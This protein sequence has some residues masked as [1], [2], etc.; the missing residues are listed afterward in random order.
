MKRP[1]LVLLA[2]VV[3]LL[4]GCTDTPSVNKGDPLRGETV[5]KVCLDCHGTEL[6]ASPQRKIKTL[7]SLRSE[8]ARWGDYYSPAF[9]AQ[10]DEDV[11][12]YLNSAFYKFR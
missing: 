5:H 10:D 11:V 9:T 7:K 6:Y 3:A 8:V 12:A 2:G 1:T 4:A